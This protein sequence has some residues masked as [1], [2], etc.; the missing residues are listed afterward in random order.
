VPSW[1]IPAGKVTVAGS[2]SFPQ[3]RE[4]QF[5]THTAQ[6][7]KEWTG[8]INLPGNYGAHTLRK[9]F[10]FI[11]RTVF[12]VGFEVLC[13]RFNHGSPRVTMRYLGLS[14]DEVNGVLLHDI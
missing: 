13:Q 14:S 3:R 2:T 9:T 5:A 4:Y 10:G 8:A 7:V 11:Q 6:M 12:G 1:A